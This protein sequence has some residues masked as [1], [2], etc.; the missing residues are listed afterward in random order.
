MVDVNDAETQ[1][2]SDQ[3]ANL[4][5]EAETLDSA[6]R[7]LWV[8]YIGGSSL[9][10]LNFSLPRG[11]WGW[12]K[13]HPDYDLLEPGDTMLF[14]AGYT[15]G[16]PRKKS[17]EFRRH[18]VSRVIVCQTASGVYQDST[19]YWPDEDEAVS[20][21]YRVDL[22]GVEEQP[23]AQLVELDERF[24]GP[25]AEAIRMSASIQGRAELVEVMASAPK[26]Q[27]TLKEV[28]DA[29]IDATSASGLS[30][31]TR[32]ETVIRSFV[33][34]LA[35]KPFVILTGLSGSGKTRLAQA[36]GQWLGAMKV[37][38]V[39][40][41]WTSPDSLLGFENALSEQSDGRY[42]WNVPDTLRFILEA[43][44]NPDQPH[45]LL[46]DEMN[47]AH[48][49]RYFADVLSGMESGEP[50]VPDLV[51]GP[52]TT[53]R[54]RKDSTE[55]APLPENL[56][57]VGTVNI[58][59]TTYMFSPKVLDRANTFEFRVETDDLVARIERRELEPAGQDLAKGFLEA[60]RLVVADCGSDGR[61][62]G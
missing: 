25:V 52:G 45:L 62:G 40:P 3:D 18:G 56:F 9:P 30:F 6:P 55:P 5:P 57:V 46:L 29:F 47:L 19:P 33:T 34:A 41:D 32:H 58:D 11:R 39:R 27:R 36:F 44:D 37:V 23:A 22:I 17:E 16:S 2:G 49:E 4:G 61:S 26:Q 10:N 24:R 15:D 59:E 43:R 31:G 28:V 13:H 38:A 14:A 8:V 54:W 7:R 1:N 21:P 60:V 51:R 48:V 50:V 20:Y 42:A 35:T 53:Y 12:K